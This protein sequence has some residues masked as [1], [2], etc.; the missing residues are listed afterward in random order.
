MVSMPVAWSNKRETERL[1][2]DAFESLQ[3]ML[4]R[5]VADTGVNFSIWSALRT[6]ADQVAIFK[7]NYTKVSRGRKLST[8][9]GYAG[10]IWARKPGGV[11]VASPDL[12]SNHQD[13]MAVD[14][15]P[16]A[17]QNWIKSNGGLYGWSWDEGRRVGE[18][19]HF[20]YISSSDGMKSEG[21]LDHGA[22]QKVVGAE[23]DGKIGTGTAAK[24]KAWQKKNGLTAD[25]KVGSTTKRAMGLGKGDAPVVVHVPDKVSKP[26]V[27]ASD[28]T[29]EEAGP[30]VNA[31][32]DRKGHSIKHATIHWWGRPSGQSYEG[33][34]DYLIDNARQVSAHYVVS[35][36]KVARILPE[37]RGAW[38]NG[39]RTAN[40]EGIVIECDPNKVLETLPTIA[41]LLAD[42]FARNGELPVYPHS[43]WTSTECPGDYLP[44]LPEIVAMA[45]GG[46]VNLGRPIV[47]PSKHKGLAEDGRWGTTTTKALQRF[48]NSRVKARKLAIDGRMGP[49]AWRSLQEYL[50]HPV[51]DGLIEHQSYKPDE[52]GNG[53]SPNGW[54]YTGR[55]SKGSKTIKRLQRW[56]GVA[57][58]GVVYEGTT[59]ALQNKLN[60][61]G[62]R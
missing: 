38:G 49:N 18:S 50:G 12:G 5:A 56:I 1:R 29:F 15:H 16:A 24:I 40:L 35:G 2:K 32:D 8:D 31:Y 26:V 57:Q 22:V 7:A 45:K 62:A 34:R 13:G 3:R 25:G 54:E 17:I 23:V 14:I 10:S 60:Q 11:S 53:I 21:V 27:A 20:R 30:A 36:N 58:D 44:Y 28:Y 4:N 51:V 47:T 48:L 9:R 33:I 37:N 39:N 52:L 61:H 19:W 42:I 43:H 55:N 59:K 46:T 6:H 41:A